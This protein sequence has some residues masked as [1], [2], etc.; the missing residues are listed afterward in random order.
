MWRNFLLATCDDDDSDDIY[1]DL[2]A[3]A[4]GRDT[5]LVVTL[6]RS[7][8][9]YLQV[10]S[11]RPRVSSTRIHEDDHPFNSTYGCECEFE[12]RPSPFE[13]DSH[14]FLRNMKFPVFSLA[15]LLSSVLA[16]ETSSEPIAEVEEFKFETEVNK[17]MD[18]IVHS[19]YKTKDVFLRELISNSADALEKVRFESI[20]GESAS[21]SELK[22]TVKADKTA[23]TL[24]IRDTGVGMSRDQLKSN[25]GTIAKSGTAEFLK[26]IEE[27]KNA[28]ALIGKV[29]N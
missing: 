6:L 16:S 2:T 1:I 27:G 12:P 19:L 14:A 21:G 22:I 20:L 26:K 11:R 29:R 8:R 4:S 7:C 28:D 9:E 15:L 17:V 5:N 3:I 25:L 24:T 13:A 18:L 10:E 23:R